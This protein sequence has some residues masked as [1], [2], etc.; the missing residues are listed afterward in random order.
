MLVYEAVYVPYII[1]TFMKIVATILLTVLRG[2][3]KENARTIQRGWRVHVKSVSSE[4]Y[5][6][7][8]TY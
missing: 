3:R 6:L 2:L 1:F 5:R 8:R 4:I 7:R